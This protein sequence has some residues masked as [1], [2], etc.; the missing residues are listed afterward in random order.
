MDTRELSQT[1]TQVMG[2]QLDRLKSQA[3]ALFGVGLLCCGI[4]FVSGG[5]DAITHFFPSYLFA[6]VFWFGATAG[7]LGLLMLH[8]TVGGGWG[9][10]L[11]RFFEAGSHW[12]MFVLMLALFVPVLVGLFQFDLYSWVTPDK[13]GA[14]TASR[15][16]AVEVVKEK[17]GYLNVP[18]FLTR[19]ACYFAFF[20]GFSLLLRKWGRVQDERL[21]ESNSGNLN[22]FSAGGILLFVLVGTF[23]SVDWVMS[24]TP[25]WFSS[26][27]GLLWVASQAL[28][29]LALMLALLAWLAGDTPLVRS[30]PDAFFRDLGN[31]MLAIVM[32]WAYM[33]FS[34]YLIIFS[35]N[36]WE[37]ATW[38]LNRRAPVWAVMGGAL[39]LAH[40]FIPFFVL[41][42]DSGLKKNPRRL[43]ALAAGIVLMRFVDLLWHVIPTFRP[44]GPH[45]TEL[46]FYVGTP[47]LLGGVWLW[48]FAEQLKDRPVVPLHDPRLQAHLPEVAH[49]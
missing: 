34:Q 49:G 23:V 48:M 5:P 21:D 10:V 9:F 31:L 35:G 22:R 19:L 40:F 16:I 29:T 28:S 36:T 45:M 25:D 12:K 20:I 11:R 8:H 1:T 2:P 3:G 13:W 37:E 6:Y 43:G 17:A 24:L 41:L 39:I 47:L 32:L 30:I 42:V 15:H 38:Y 44:G 26:I 7:S 14:E 27:Y 33:S 4:S 46:A 18:A